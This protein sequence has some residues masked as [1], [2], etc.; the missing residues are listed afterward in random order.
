[1]QNALLFFSC[2]HAVE[3]RKTSETWEMLKSGFYRIV[4]QTSGRLLLRNLC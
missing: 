1:M 2:Y 4:R 3:L